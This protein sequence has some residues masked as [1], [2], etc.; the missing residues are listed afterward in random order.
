MSFLR[1]LRNA[2]AFLTIIPVGMDEKVFDD[3][4]DVM[5]L[6]PLYGALIGLISGLVGLALELLRAPSIVWATAVYSSLLIVTGFNHM[7]GL[8]DFADAA[9]AQAPKERRLQIMKDQYTGAAAISVGLVVA[10]V[11][12]A[13]LSSLSREV[14]VRAVVISEAVAKL[15]MVISIFMGP[16]AREGLG[17]LF[18]NK[19]K[20][21]RKVAKLAASTSMCLAFSSLLGLVGLMAC[22]A[23]VFASIV[24]VGIARRKFGGLTGDVMGAVNEISRGVTLAAVAVSLRWGLRA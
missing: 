6:S 3:A 2:L 1:K 4:A 20:E 24:I 21:R 10:L 9:V 11:T 5:W 8:L 17:E 12:V 23:G 15:G 16:P 18:I 19:F 14:L 7:D 22:V 13:S